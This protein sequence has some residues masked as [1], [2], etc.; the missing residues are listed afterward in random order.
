MAIAFD[1][2]ADGN[3]SALSLTY[4]HTCTGASI[5]IVGVCC[6]SARTISSVTYNGVGL[7]FVNRSAGGG[8][9]QTS[10]WYYLVNPAAGANNVV[11]TIDSSSF[12]FGSS[13]SYTGAE[14]SSPIDANTTLSTTGAISVTTTT[15]NCWCMVCC[16]DADDGASTAGT[17][18][19]S[20]VSNNFQI[21]DSNAPV[22]PAGSFS[23][24]VNNLGG[25]ST[26]AMIAIKPSAAVAARR[27]LLLGIGT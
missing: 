11:I 7:T 19:T 1:A 3:A 18:C 5:L 22:T 20:R 4:S 26:Q 14:T 27:L 10:A 16:R 21:Y 23:M 8:G 13:A 12:I 6:S 24:T 9:G 2:A 17:N 15:N 25:N